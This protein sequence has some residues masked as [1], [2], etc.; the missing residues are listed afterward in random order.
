MKR[1]V[2]SRVK[3]ILDVVATVATLGVLA[4]LSYT[5]YQDRSNQS[6]AMASLK[7]RQQQTAITKLPDIDYG[8]RR[9]TV[10][11][12]ITT[13]CDYCRQ[14]MPFYRTLQSNAE[15]DGSNMQL[16]FISPEQRELVQ[17]FLATNSVHAEVQTVDFAE[18]G[19]GATPTL[20][21][22]DRAGHLMR[23]WRGRLSNE[24]QADLL[25]T[26]R[27]LTGGT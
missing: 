16:V 20:V 17:L 10:L 4:Y 13:K 11:V 3:Q 25:G 1:T 18:H 6:S 22:V 5:F 14:S 26:L 9:A 12:A 15:A 19:I 2:W 24:Q 7:K 27:T 8:L 21:M 23:Q